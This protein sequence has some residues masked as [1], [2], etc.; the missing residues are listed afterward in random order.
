MTLD[1]GSSLKQYLFTISHDLALTFLSIDLPVVHRLSLVFV[2]RW[3]HTWILDQLLA[4]YLHLLLRKLKIITSFNRLIW[5]SI[6]SRPLWRSRRRKRGSWLFVISHV[7][8]ILFRSSFFHWR[9]FLL[10]KFDI[11]G[12]DWDSHA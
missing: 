12:R 11:W 4:I 5:I 8:Q 3:K 1:S 9:L 2:G 7:I 6:D 10:L